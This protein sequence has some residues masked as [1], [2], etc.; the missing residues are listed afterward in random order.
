[1]ELIAVK[2]SDF[3]PTPPAPVSRWVPYVSRVSTSC[4]LVF[5]FDVG[6]STYSS[7]SCGK[8]ESP[9]AS[10]ISS[11]ALTDAINVRERGGSF[12]L[13]DEVA[14]NVTGAGLADGRIPPIRVSGPTFWLK[15]SS[16]TT[17]LSWSPPSSCLA[18]WYH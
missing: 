10:S 15:V 14:S 11:G 2:G 4:F 17:P 3:L 1:V 7:S 13:V 6:G 18:C 8:S 9:K 12:L 5:P 16:R